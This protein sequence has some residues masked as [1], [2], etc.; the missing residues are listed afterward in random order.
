MDADACNMPEEAKRTKHLSRLELVAFIPIKPPHRTDLT[1][2]GLCVNGT[3]NDKNGW[4]PNSLV[5]LGANRVHDNGDK[6]Q[7]ITSQTLAFFRLE[8]E[9]LNSIAN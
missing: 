5:T 1:A 4:K 8:I 2:M 9:R 3:C 7:Q 6:W